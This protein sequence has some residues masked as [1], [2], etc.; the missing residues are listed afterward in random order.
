MGNGQHTA[1]G[2]DVQNLAAHLVLNTDIEFVQVAMVVHHVAEI[3]DK[4]EIVTAKL[5]AQVKIT[6]STHTHT[7]IIYQLPKLHTRVF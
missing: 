2:Q 7:H 1:G 6:H 4:K 5:L 3:Q